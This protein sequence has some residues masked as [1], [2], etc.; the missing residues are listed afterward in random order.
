MY[1]LHLLEGDSAH[2][3]SHHYHQFNRRNKSCTSS[4]PINK[5]K[6]M[7]TNTKRLRQVDNVNRCPISLSFSL[8]NTIKIRSSYTY[9][10]PN[11][12]KNSMVFYGLFFSKYPMNKNIV[13]F[14][15]F[16]FHLPVN[17]IFVLFELIIDINTVHM[18]GS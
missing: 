2:R 7:T 1:K 11:K 10:D 6:L 17:H 3:V 12:E 5:I 16:G 13:C 14:F 4:L 8:Q 9:F 15:L 18:I